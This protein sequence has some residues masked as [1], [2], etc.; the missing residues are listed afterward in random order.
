MMRHF[1]RPAYRAPAFDRPDN[2]ARAA[3]SLIGHPKLDRVSASTMA[4]IFMLRPETALSLI[5]KARAEVRT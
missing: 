1:A 4:A 3:A 2:V 5:A